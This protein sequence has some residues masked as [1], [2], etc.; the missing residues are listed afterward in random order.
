MKIGHM[1]QFWCANIFI[2]AFVLCLNAQHSKP[3]TLEALRI[4][5][6][7]NFD[8]NPDEA[9]WRTAQHINNFTQRELHFGEPASEKTETAILYDNY[10]LYIGVW[11]YMQNPAKTV[12]KFMSR[13]FNYENDDVF[14]VL[15]SPFND[16]RNGYLFIIN[17]NAAR[18]DLQ[19]SRENDN[20]DWNGV[21][22]AK[23]IRND[24][25]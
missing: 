13:D 12:A 8:G 21:W 11:C 23:T 20:I 16:G 14:G 9:V 6:K 1:K 19:V 7:I 2:Y 17:P 18:S 5:T 24:K 10:N 4:N 22:D 25:G 3:D 15:I